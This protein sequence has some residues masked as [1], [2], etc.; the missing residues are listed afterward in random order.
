[1][2]KHIFKGL[3][4]TGVLHIL[5]NL[6]KIY[7]LDEINALCKTICL[8]REMDNPAEFSVKFINT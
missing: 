5:K 6:L 4:I 8:Q 7:S 1:M 3:Y 2:D